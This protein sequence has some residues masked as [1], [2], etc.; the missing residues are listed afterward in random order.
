MQ[1]VI[2][3]FFYEM[4]LNQYGSKFTGQII[5]GLSNN[6]VVT[7]RVN[8]IK[9]DVEKIKNELKK[10][11]IKY[12][13][14]E[15]YKDALII[16]NTIEDEIRKLEIYNKGEIY[17]QSLSSMIPPLF[18]N[19]QSGEN[20]LDMTAA[21]G[22]KTTQIAAL[23]KN[24]AMITAC[25]KNKIRA[26]RLKYNINLQ[27]VKHVNIM[28]QDATKLD[29]LFAFDKILLD[30]PCSGSGTINLNND[31]YKKYFTK[32]SVERSVKTQI[33]LLKKAIKI[34]KPGKEMIYSTCS[35]LFWENE[36]VLKN[37][38]KE[39][40]AEIV[41]IN[42]PVDAVLLPVKIRG[43]ICIAPNDF[44]EGFFIAK[45]KKKE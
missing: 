33:E 38:L 28:I 7:L 44:Y 12:K 15:W 45:I 31:K 37:A 41:P 36:N 27:G 11:N 19:P 32:E 9:T 43:T 34:L 5:K 20:I 18:L 2:P 23:S 16:R 26:E 21:P 39:S 42:L 14:V 6:R 13:Q 25:E 24:N 40:N 4:L 29:D 17:L 30:A 35:I 10:A 22:G 1:K 3:D 8:T